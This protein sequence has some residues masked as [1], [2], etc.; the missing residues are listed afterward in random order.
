MKHLTAEETKLIIKPGLLKSIYSDYDTFEKFFD[1]IC[2]ELRF[3][4]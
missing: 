4:N 3:N 1:V 2:N